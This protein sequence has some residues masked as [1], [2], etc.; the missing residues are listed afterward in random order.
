MEPSLLTVRCDDPTTTQSADDELASS[1]ISLDEVE[2]AL[3]GDEKRGAVF[4]GVPGQ[5][6]SPKIHPTQ[7]FS[8]AKK[9]C[10]SRHTRSATE[11][12][13]CP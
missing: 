7:R 8:T 12:F 13:D 3:N 9:V 11:S 5:V 10:C 1:T 4:K 2:R 6:D